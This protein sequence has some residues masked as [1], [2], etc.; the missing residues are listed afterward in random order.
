MK[1]RLEHANITV[2]SIH[3]AVK[4]LT[5][6]FPHFKVRGGQKTDLGDFQKEWL[7]LGTDDTY[8][9]LEEVTLEPGNIRSRHHDPGI[10][11]IG[12][13]VDDM[14]TLTDRLR[15]AGYEA[16]ELIEEGDGPYRKRIYVLDDVG[17]EWEFVQYL[18]DDPDKAN[19]YSL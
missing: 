2:E 12:F 4:F 3:K 19:D 7:H 8:I 11:H 18:T 14:T 6:A 9:A 5:T 17:N 10:N 1:C 16:G 13:V 15:E